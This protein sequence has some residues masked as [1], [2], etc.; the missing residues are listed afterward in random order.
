M[1]R[2]QMVMTQAGEA[3]GS[4]ASQSHQQ[5]LSHTLLVSTPYGQAQAHSVEEQQEWQEKRH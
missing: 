3:P 2:S 5:H 4:T 1:V